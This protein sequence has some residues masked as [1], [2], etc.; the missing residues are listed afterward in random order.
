MKLLNHRIL[1]DFKQNLLEVKGLL[2]NSGAIQVQSSGC[3]FYNI[4]QVAGGTFYVHGVT[5][6]VYDF[7]A[8][9]L[10]YGYPSFFFAFLFFFFF[11][12]LRFLVFILAFDIILLLGHS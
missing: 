4:L 2:T 10:V 5:A 8:S 1:F 9:G 12:F 6:N 3:F 7:T 11:P